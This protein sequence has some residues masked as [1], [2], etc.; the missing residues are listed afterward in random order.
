[1][2]FT[3]DSY[4][5]QININLKFGCLIQESVTYVHPDAVDTQKVLQSIEIVW[6]I[7]HRRCSQTPAKRIAIDSKNRMHNNRKDFLDLPDRATLK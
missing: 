3:R 2:C 1:M 4:R 7:L 6:R 5:Q